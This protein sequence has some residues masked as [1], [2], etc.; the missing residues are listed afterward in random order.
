MRTSSNPLIFNPFVLSLSKDGRIKNPSQIKPFM[1]R[2]A[3]HER[4]DLTCAHMVAARGEE[5]NEKGAGFD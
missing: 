4:L 1:L 2:Q 5:A 3:Q